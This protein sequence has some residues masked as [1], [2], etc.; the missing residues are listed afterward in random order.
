MT[1]HHA[2]PWALALAMALVGCGAEPQGG[3]RDSLAV[4]TEGLK[5]EQR[6]VLIQ[7]AL[8]YSRLPSYVTG[9][10]WQGG[11]TATLR[12]GAPVYICREMN[13]EFGLSA[14]GWSQIA[15]QAISSEAWGYGWVPTEELG[16]W[17]GE[18]QQ[19]QR[20][21]VTTEWTEV[22]ASPPA[23]VTGIGWQ[24]ERVTTLRTGTALYVFAEQD[25]E[26]G[27]STK[28]YLQVA[29]LMDSV[30]TFGWVLADDIDLQ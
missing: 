27:F 10:G 16:P 7:N 5:C 18:S 12:K 1:K 26:Y 30:W 17:T 4:G 11:S 24:G 3:D 21:G 20:R 22:F 9:V 28:D 2:N 25:V 23:F 15:Y 19:T 6:G 13:A 29:F 14:K 8:A